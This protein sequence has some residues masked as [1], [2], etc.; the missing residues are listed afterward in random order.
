VPGATSVRATR[1]YQAIPPYYLA[2]RFGIRCG[3]P[4]A[5]ECDQTRRLA[6]LASRLRTDVTTLI[7]GWKLLLAT[8]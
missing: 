4:F 5:G 6:F 7:P 8:G 3:S 2:Q 1:Y